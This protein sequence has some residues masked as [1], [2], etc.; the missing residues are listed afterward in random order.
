MLRHHFPGVQ[1]YLI[2][3]FC[4]TR[5]TSHFEQ[6]ILSYEKISVRNLPLF[7]N[8][9]TS[10]RNKDVDVSLEFVGTGRPRP[11]KK[12]ENRHRLDSDLISKIEKMVILL[13]PF[14]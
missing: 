1:I 13:W 2:T 14:C 10:E 12:L 4:Q 3:L 5:V 8:Y 9:R 6:K 11:G 7:R